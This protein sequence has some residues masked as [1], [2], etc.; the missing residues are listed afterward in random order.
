RSSRATGDAAVR[1]TISIATALY[2]LWR[3]TDSDR[4]RIA[5]L[6]GTVQVQSIT[7]Q[8][9]A[10]KQ[11]PRRARPRRQLSRRRPLPGPD[12]V[13]CASPQSAN[14]AVGTK[15]LVGTPTLDSFL[16]L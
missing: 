14:L 15:K 6:V 9:S 11:H 7:V 3:R 13:F 2:H 8:E 10:K 1:G 12:F 4:C 5:A 16:Q